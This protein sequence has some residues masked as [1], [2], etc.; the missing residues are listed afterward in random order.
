[1]SILNVS[2]PLIPLAFIT[3]YFYFSGLSSM[4]NLFVLRSHNLIT[5]SK[6][7]VHNAAG[8]VIYLMLVKGY[9]WGLNDIFL[10]ILVLFGEV[11]IC[12]LPSIPTKS[13]SLCTLRYMIST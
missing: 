3:T 12:K 9:L 7:D 1:M 2:I 11:N 5:P 13:H 8:L 10:T 6:E 4:S